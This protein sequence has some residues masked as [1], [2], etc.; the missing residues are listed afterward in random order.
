MTFF[1]GC[2]SLWRMD[3]ETATIPETSPRPDTCDPV[4]ETPSLRMTQS[5]MMTVMRV[6]ILT[7]GGIDL[8]VRVLVDV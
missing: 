6:M 7:A 3:P 2:H 4:C 8:S 5:R 1:W